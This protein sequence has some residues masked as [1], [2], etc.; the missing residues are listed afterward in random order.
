MKKTFHLISVCV[1]S[2]FLLSAC[3]GAPAAPAPVDQGPTVDPNL[4]FTSGAQ[5]VVAQITLDAANRPVPTIAIPPTQTMDPNLAP[6]MDPAG[7]PADGQLPVLPGL[8][9][10]TTPGAPAGSVVTQPAAAVP[11]FGTVNTLA[12]AAPA[13]PAGT[14]VAQVPD[15]LKWESNTPP[16]KSTLKAGTK[17]KITWKLSN[18]G[19]TTWNDTYSFKFYAGTQLATQS[20]YAVTKDVAPNKSYDFT[21]NAVAPTTPGDYYSLWVL[22]R[23]DGVNVGKFDITLTVQ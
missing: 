11:T 17:F 22:Q 10:N 7:V 15:R 16:D 14:V 19:T 2:V 13:A 3:G 21:V 4:V 6:T 20:A 18:V 9:E 1:I 8:P 23:Q 5:T 12:P